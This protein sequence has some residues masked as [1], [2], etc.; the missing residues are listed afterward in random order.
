[1]EKKRHTRK[2]L[3][4]AGKQKR[5]LYLSSLHR[6]SCHDYE[7]VKACF[8]AED[9]WFK[10]FIIGLDLGFQGFADLYPCK[11]LFIPLK[12]KRVKKGHCNE[13][14]EEQKLLNKQ[15]AQQRVGIEH[16]I[17]GMKR[18][19]ILSNRLRLKSTILMDTLIGVCAGLWNFLLNQ[20]NSL[21]NNLH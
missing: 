20:S 1:V 18:Y 15:Q 10:K 11:K 8:P 14:S 19:R 2:S 3:F 13:L 7:I 21:I 6:G 16:S 5:I 9:N 12:R 17:G 4:V